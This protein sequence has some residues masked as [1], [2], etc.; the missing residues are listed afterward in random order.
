MDAT[1]LNALRQTVGPDNVIE[2]T[3]PRYF[4][5]TYGDATLYRSR[6]DAIVYPGSTEEVVAL[7]KLA[8]EHNTFLVPAGGLTGLSG[9]AVSDGGLQLNLSRM[10]RVKHV[11]PIGR[12]VVVEPGLSCAKLNEELARRGFVVPVAPA[13]HAISTIGANVAEGAGGTWGMSKGNFRN[14][15]LT[16]EIVDGQGRVFQTGRPFPKQ[17]TGPDLTGLFLGSEG[18]L[19]IITEVTLR[20]DEVPA[21]TWTIRTAFADESVL[22]AIHEGVAA[23]GVSLY[24]FEYMDGQLMR[25]LGKEPQ[26]LLLLQTA[27]H[28]DKA[29]A[30][31]EKVV[32]V[33]QA[34][35]PAELVYTND[36]A[37]ADELYAE[38]R[39]ALGALAKA[40]RNK[41]V[42]VQFDPILPTAIFAEGVN[43]MRELA[44]KAGLD[45]I[46]Y[47]HAGDGNLHPSFIL[48]DDLE[49]KQKAR[50][51]IREYDAWIEARGGVFAGEHGVGFFLGRDMKD[52]RPGCED[53]LRAIKKAFDPHGILNPGKVV[54]TCELP[55]AMAP[56]LPQYRA[57]ADTCALCAKC[58]LCKNDS[59]LFQAEPR[60]HNT[61]RGRV[62]MIDAATRGQVSFEAIRP[63]VHEVQAWIANGWNCPTFIKEAMPALLDQ[64]VAAQ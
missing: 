63:F 38:R 17:S 51:V 31:A 4:A 25:A 64:A 35:E 56:V 34:L 11:D 8:R 45:I 53:Y 20:L 6:P 36:K 9:G 12:T 19:G 10:T 40:D 39:S 43:K 59:P 44:D 21:D 57:I 52:I 27:G 48:P 3:D 55:M 29:K 22:Q 13:S 5:Y 26:M 23:A 16:L 30:D 54:D 62:S 15:L 24:S 33:L 58:H 47:G 49:A 32:K 41:P 37:Q 60:E 2:P 50:A 28:P 46:I 14:Y 42:I 18:T 1:L 61:I 7:V